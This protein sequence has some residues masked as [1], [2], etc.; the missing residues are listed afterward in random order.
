MASKTATPNGIAAGTAD[1]RSQPHKLTSNRQVERLLTLDICTLLVCDVVADN[2]SGVSGARQLH[3]EDELA[4]GSKHHL[5][6]DQVEFPHPGK[7]FVIK[8]EYGVA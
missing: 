2:R 1:V 5:C 7:A 4:A 6:A 8:G 3:M